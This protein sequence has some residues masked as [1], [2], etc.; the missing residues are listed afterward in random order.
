MH[1]W[2]STGFSQSFAEMCVCVCVFFLLF[3]IVKNS[4]SDIKN[5]P[6]CFKE[7]I[8]ALDI[9]LEIM[10]TSIACRTYNVLL[11]EGRRIGAAL[12]AL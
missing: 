4:E 11:G 7:R 6:P 9:G 8:E 2:G 3:F 10:S 1:L 12:L 5:I